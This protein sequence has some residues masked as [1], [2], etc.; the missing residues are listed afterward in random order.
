VDCLEVVLKCEL[1]Q[2]RVVIRVNVRYVSEEGVT[3]QDVAA[4]EGQDVAWR[5]GDVEHLCTE[6]QG[7]VFGNGEVF[8][9]REI[10]LA[11]VRTEERIANKV[12]DGAERLRSEG[13]WVEP[14]GAA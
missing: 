4:A 12:A 14:E 5:V 10:D 1:H 8:E 6:L 11:I 7:T 2:A 13:I 3:Q 9:Q